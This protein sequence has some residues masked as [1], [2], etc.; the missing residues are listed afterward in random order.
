MAAALLVVPGAR[1]RVAV[2][3]PARAASPRVAQLPAGGA[4][5]AAVGLR[6]AGARVADPGGR[7]AVGVGHER[8]QHLVADPRLQRPR[9]AVRPGR[10]AGR[11]R[12][13]P[14]GGGGG[15]GGVFGGD[16]GPLRLLNESARRAGRLAAGLRARRAASRCSSSTRLRR[17]DAAHRLADRGRRLVR[18]RPPWPSASAEGIFHPYYVVAARA[19][20]GGSWSA[21]ASACCCAAGVPARIARPARRSPRA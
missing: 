3:R 1:R 8:Q 21:P 4:A 2:G 11:R 16:A 19:V 20:H 6:L 15:G 9:P 14:G 12:R 7:P 18:S 10:R 17:A 13:W 5:M